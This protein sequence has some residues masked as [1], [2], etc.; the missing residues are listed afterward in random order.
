MNDVLDVA[1]AVVVARVRLAG[2]DKL[3]RPRLV[4]GQAD[5]VFDLLEISG[6]RL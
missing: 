4:A 3:N 5:D 2:E 1:L 6:A